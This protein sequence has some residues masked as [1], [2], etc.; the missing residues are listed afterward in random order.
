V[1]STVDTERISR[2]LSAV[3]VVLGALVVA[4]GALVG[5]LTFV[6]LGLAVVLT[7]VVLY[8]ASGWFFDWYWDWLGALQ[9][10]DV[11]PTATLYAIVGALVVG[12]WTGGFVALWWIAAFG[13]VLTEAA[14]D[15][16]LLSLGTVARGVVPGVVLGG[17]LLVVFRVLWSRDPSFEITEESRAFQLI[18][19]TVLCTLGAYCLLLFRHPPSAATFAVAYLGSLV[20]VAAVFLTQ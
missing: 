1:T 16:N 14:L 13:G 18:S 6:G 7:G 4:L 19:V 20:I 9:N 12:V 5:E 17:G 15:G 11:E 3:I 8:W 10:G 2:L